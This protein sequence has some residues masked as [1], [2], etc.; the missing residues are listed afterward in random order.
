MAN[1]IKSKKPAASKNERKPIKV[2]DPNDKGLRAFNDSND[3]YKKTESWLQE[4]K[5]KFGRELDSLVPIP[6]N[7]Y[8]KEG[9]IYPTAKAWI[10]QENA[11][12][13]TPYYKKPVQ[14]YKL[15]KKKPAVKTPIKPAQKTVV[16]AEAKPAQKTEAKEDKKFYQGRAFMDSTRLRP[17]YYT[18]S[19]VMNAVNKKKNT[20]KK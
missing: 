11:G 6:K 15:E 12:Y 13:S 3:L 9:V 10:Y 5:K 1:I 18:K 4:N 2:T 20:K 17:N 7:N 8:K 16:K 14:P 19:E